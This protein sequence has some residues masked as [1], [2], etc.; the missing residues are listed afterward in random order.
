VTARHDVPRLHA[1]DGLRAAMMLLGLVL[2][3]ATS[4][5]ATPLGDAWPYQDGSTSTAFDFVVFIIHLFRMPAFFVMAGFFAALLYYRSGPADLFVHR[6]KRVLVPLALAW[7]VVF[8][9]VRLGFGYAVSRGGS[10]GGATVSAA[11]SSGLYAEPS[12][13]HLW[14]LYDLFIFYLV[15]LAAMPLVERLPLLIRDGAVRAFAAIVPRW[16]APVAL[17]AVS[18]ITLLPMAK[19]ALE[20]S[21]SFA[22]PIRVL[23][24]YLV[25]FGFG[26]LLF[27]CRELV[28]SFARRAWLQTVAGLVVSLAYM[29]AV[30]SPRVQSREGFLV[31]CVLAAVAMWLLIYASIGLFVRYFD[32]HRPVQRY[33]ADGAYWIYLVHLPLAIAVPGLLSPLGWPAAAKFAVT[34]AATTGV[35]VVTYHYLVRSTAIGVLLNGRRY[36][37]ALP[38]P[39]QPAVAA[40]TGAA[41]PA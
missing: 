27:N 28:P 25:F 2:H 37:R 11:A 14:F 39:D 1:L 12:L 6:V 22:P 34:L 29:A 16:W 3:S 13:V 21:V 5:T 8:P 10:T 26:W 4:Y 40:A 24:A 19:P 30:L 23:V 18:A 32:A 38:S 17:S 7:V 36:P 31:A 41:G 35:T 20:T 15:A 33:V 9:L